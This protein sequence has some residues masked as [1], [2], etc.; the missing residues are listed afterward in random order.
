MNNN[1]NKLDNNR[2]IL[3]LLSHVSI[4]FAS[5]G[6]AVGIPILIMG[7][8]QDSVVKENAK[9][10]LNFF[11]TCYILGFICLVLIFAVIGFPLLILLGI[12]SVIMPIMASLKVAQNPDRSY[13]YPLILRLF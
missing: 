4:L 10:A 2:K 5:T 13:R 1:P 6:I 8:S 7:L 12:A 9:E 11:I 3:S